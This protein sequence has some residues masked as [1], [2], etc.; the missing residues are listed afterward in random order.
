MGGLLSTTEKIK[1]APKAGKYY[2]N[3]ADL[4]TA[5]EYL[6]KAVASKN[7]EILV[8]DEIGKM[9]SCSVEFKKAVDKAINSEK[10]LIAVVS[11]HLAE[12]YAEKGDLVLVEKER[13]KQYKK[14]N[15]LVFGTDQ[16]TLIFKTNKMHEK[17]EHYRNIPRGYQRDLMRAF[18]EHGD[19]K[20][21]EFKD[22]IIGDVADIDK[23]FKTVKSKCEERE[24]LAMA[25][26]RLVPIYKNIVFA[27]DIFFELAKDEIK[28]YADAIKNNETFYVRIER[29]G[30]KG[31]LNSQKEEQKLDDFMLEELKKEI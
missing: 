2:V 20:R 6:Q 4:K 27:P 3:L 21:T 9:E 16:Y 7:T 29:R 26:S 31:I 23:F 22:V 17:V 8:I 18:L 12:K 5:S 19:F 30:L 24:D 14:E 1:D 25:L 28:E 11:Q 10:R 13:K 15:F